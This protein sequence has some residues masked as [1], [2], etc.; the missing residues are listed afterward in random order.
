MRRILIALLALTMVFA[1]SACG[2]SSDQAQTDE[3][4]QTEEAAGGIGTHHA[5]IDIADYGTVKLELDGDTA[6]ITVQNFMDLAKAGFYDG[7]TTKL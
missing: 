2:E 6:P 4:V 7:L 5:E 3:Q 1:V